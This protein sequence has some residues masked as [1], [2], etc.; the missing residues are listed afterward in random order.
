MSARIVLYE[1]GLERNLDSYNSEEI[2][3]LTNAIVDL[4]GSRCTVDLYSGYVF[5]I[6]QLF[7]NMFCISGQVF[8]L[9][10]ENNTQIEFILEEDDDSYLATIESSSS[11]EEEDEDEDF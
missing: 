7:I 5:S 10:F 4:V 1:N 6:N 2:N 11:D 8:Q 3:R 9:D